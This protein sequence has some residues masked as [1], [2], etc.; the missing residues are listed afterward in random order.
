MPGLRKRAPDPVVGQ[1]DPRGAGRTACLRHAVGLDRL[2]ENWARLDSFGRKGKAL[3]IPPDWH[4]L[5]WLRLGRSGREGGDRPLRFFAGPESQVVRRYVNDHCQHNEECG[6]P[7]K[8]TVMHPFPVWTVRRV[9][10][11][12]G[13]A[14]L[15]ELGIIHGR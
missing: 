9:F 15:L 11:G 10:G 6:H 1:D 14:V 7:E 5:A 12:V 2:A 3:K 8:R 4:G 13:S